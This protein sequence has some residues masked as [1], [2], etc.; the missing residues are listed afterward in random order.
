MCQY[1]AGRMLTVFLFAHGRG[2]ALAISRIAADGDIKLI[3]Q[4]VQR[5]LYFKFVDHGVL[6]FDSL[7]KYAAEYLRGQCN[8]I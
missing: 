7:A 2:L 4:H 6:H 8:S 5:V 3:K 1:G